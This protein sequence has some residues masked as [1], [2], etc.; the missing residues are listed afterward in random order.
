M[1]QFANI[2]AQKIGCIPGV[3]VHL[4]LRENATPK[5]YPPRTIPYALK[6]KVNQELKTLEENRII[7]K[8]DI[9]DW[10]SPTVAIVKPDQLVRLCANYKLAVNDQLVNANYPI[11]RINTILHSLKNSKY[12]YT[13]DL[14]KA[15]LYVKV[16][17]KSS[18]IQAILTPQGTYRVNRLC[19]GIKTVPTEFNRILDAILRNVAN[20]IAYFDDIIIHGVTKEECGKNLV[21]CLQALSKNDLHLNHRKC[22]FYKE[23]IDY[24]GYRISL[25]QVKKSPKKIEAILNLPKP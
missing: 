7:E 1:A 18:E 5:Y 8:A 17:K 15:Y 4:E 20:T 14:Y 10:G 11:E 19:F 2:F 3:E 25:N 12:F 13:L 16:D 21:E 24:L 22:S 9:C 23:E 6:E